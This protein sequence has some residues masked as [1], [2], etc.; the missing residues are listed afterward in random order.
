MGVTAVNEATAPI[1]AQ[2]IDMLRPIYTG[3]M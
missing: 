3:A 2:L 1:Q